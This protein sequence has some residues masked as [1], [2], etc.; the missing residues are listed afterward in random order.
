M[1]KE[2]ASVRANHRLYVDP[3]SKKL[4]PECEIIMLL[5]KPNYVHDKKGG[6]IKRE[7]VVEEVRTVM[8]PEGLGQLIDTLNMAKAGLAT[9][10]SMADE[11]NKLL[12]K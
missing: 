7:Y 3:E 9:H 1:A 8:G 10:V 5:V 2:L 12:K 6:N 11:L 4:I